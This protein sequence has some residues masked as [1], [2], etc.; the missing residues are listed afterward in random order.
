MK[1]YIIIPLVNL[2]KLQSR[3]MSGTQTLGI[4][5]LLQYL[6]FLLLFFIFSRISL[7]LIISSPLSFVALKSFISLNSLIDNSNEIILI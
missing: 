4:L 1:K 5:F 3:Q 7:L 6:Y 2:I